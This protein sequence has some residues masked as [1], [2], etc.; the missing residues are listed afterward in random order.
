MLATASTIRL[1]NEDEQARWTTLKSVELRG[2]THM[3]QLARPVRP[4]LADEA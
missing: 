2:R 3:T 4:T 1:A